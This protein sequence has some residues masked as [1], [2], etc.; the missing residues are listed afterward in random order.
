MNERRRREQAVINH[1]RNVAAGGD[2][3]DGM[4]EVKWDEMI[5]L[6]DAVY[7]L[8]ALELGPTD[9]VR[10]RGVVVTSEMAAAFMHGRKA[11]ELSGL[12]LRWLIERQSVTGG[13][14][15]D[16]LVQLIQRPHQSVSARVNELRD[17]GWL[18]DSG[19]TRPTR[20][21]QDAVVWRL[22]ARGHAELTMALRS[23]RES[24]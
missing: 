4:V 20:S 1:A 2:T 14:T 17:N 11:R 19:D 18:E 7:N 21:R 15:V 9:R 5:H 6:R 10:S 8:D 3:A 22:T 23:P 12:I 13:Y 24:T 16:E